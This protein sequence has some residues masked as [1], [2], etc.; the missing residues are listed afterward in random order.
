MIFDSL[1][2]VAGATQASPGP[3]KRPLAI[4][5]AFASPDHQS[6]L[7]DPEGGDRSDNGKLRAKELQRRTTLERRARAKR[8]GVQASWRKFS[9][10]L[11][12]R[13]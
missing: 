2:A 1:A 7:V 4:S 5:I 11:R 8:G 13:P 12:T 6:T 10:H 3:D 9:T